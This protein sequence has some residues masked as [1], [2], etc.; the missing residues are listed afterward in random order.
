[1]QKLEARN[2]LISRRS[3]NSTR[4]HAALP[5]PIQRLPL[6]PPVRFCV[7]LSV[8]SKTGESP[9][10]SALAKLTSEFPKI[11]DRLVTQEQSSSIFEW[12]SGC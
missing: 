2:S 1:M 7:V 6:S 11:S 3:L 10:L 12:H 8:F 9:L 5:E 4:F